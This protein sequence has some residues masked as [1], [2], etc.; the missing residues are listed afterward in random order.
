MR[1]KSS[2]IPLTVYF[3]KYVSKDSSSSITILVAREELLLD[4]VQPGGESAHTESL[5]ESLGLQ[6]HSRLNKALLRQMRIIYFCTGAD[7]GEYL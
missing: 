2:E 3:E 4:S 1:P 7:R 6:C 5:S